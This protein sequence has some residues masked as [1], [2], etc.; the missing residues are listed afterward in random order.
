[1]DGKMGGGDDDTG[2]GDY[3]T[4]PSVTMKPKPQNLDG[5]VHIWDKDRLEKNTQSKWSVLQHI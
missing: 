3:D 2:K 5:N 1:M 4:E